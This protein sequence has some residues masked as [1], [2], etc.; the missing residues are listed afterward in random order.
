VDKQNE[1]E[2]TVDDKAGLV[3]VGGAEVVG[4]DAL[5]PALVGEGDVAQVQDGGVLHHSVG[6]RG[7]AVAVVG[8]HVGVVLRLAVAEQLLVLA[9]REGHRGAAAAGRRAGEAHVAAQDGD[10]GLRLHGDLGLREVV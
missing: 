7:A 9:P 3:G 2:P 10:G 1:T 6:R 4:D 5:V 8:A